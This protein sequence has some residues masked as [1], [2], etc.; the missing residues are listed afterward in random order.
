MEFV[1]PNK[2]TEDYFR[3]AFEDKGLAEIVKLHM[4]QV[5]Y[6]YNLYCN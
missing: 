1:P 3:S 2:R 6:L 4:N 5:L